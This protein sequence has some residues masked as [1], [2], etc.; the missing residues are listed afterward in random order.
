LAERAADARLGAQRNVDGARGARRRQQ[1]QADAS[2]K[3]PACVETLHAA[4]ITQSTKMLTKRLDRLREVRLQAGA[5]LQDQR[6]K[7]LLGEV[8]GVE[9]VVGL[10]VLG[11]GVEGR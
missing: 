2:G 5:G 8:E 7:R 10:A 11:G 3:P 6:R 9:E 4:T 1:R